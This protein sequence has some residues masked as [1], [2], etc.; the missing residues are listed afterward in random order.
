MCYID[1]GVPDKNSQ[2]RFNIMTGLTK[3]QKGIV[4]IWR[5]II[6]CLPG[7]WQ[8]RY[9]S[10]MDDSEAICGPIE[11]IKLHR[12]KNYGLYL[13]FKLKWT[14][15][16]LPIG[17]WVFVE[18]GGRRG[19]P[20]SDSPYPFIERGGGIRIVVPTNCGTRRWTIHDDGI[21]TDE[22]DDFPTEA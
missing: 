17:R 11:T 8:G 15:K 4:R 21:P 6:N 12:S 7:L 1:F 20:F 2:T 22:I 16:C 14:A 10:Y 5:T 3:R 18:N 19:I 13:M 9:L